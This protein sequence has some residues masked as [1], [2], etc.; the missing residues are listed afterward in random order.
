MGGWE[1]FT[2]NGRE[3]R[4]GGDGKFSKSLDIV[5]RGVLIPLFYEDPT[6]LPSPP[7]SNV[8]HPSPQLPCH[9]QLPPPLF[10]LLSC[11]FSGM[12]DHTTFDDT[13][14]LGQIHLISHT[15]KHKNTHTAHSGTSRLTYPYKY[16]FTPPV[17]C[18]QQLP[19]L[20]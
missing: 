12:G 6:M 7:F 17:I 18:S 4:N 9:I 1:I 15:N 14:N 19:L 20:H 11:F 16:I 3:A 2:R 8:V 5:D 13:Y 10:F